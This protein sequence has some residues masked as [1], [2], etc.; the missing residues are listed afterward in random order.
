MRFRNVCNLLQDQEFDDLNLRDHG[1]VKSQ[2]MTDSAVQGQA[3]CS[4]CWMVEHLLLCRAPLP[5]LGFGGQGEALTSG[6]AT[7]FNVS[8]CRI[9][10]C[11][12]GAPPMHRKGEVGRNSSGLMS[13]SLLSRIISCTVYVIFHIQVREKDPLHS[14][15]I[16]VVT[17]LMCLFYMAVDQ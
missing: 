12:W 13:L 6:R 15:H 16:D 1:N 11:S 7:T 8:A 2:Q 14:Y 5:L 3:M 17:R 10:G 9:N 4:F